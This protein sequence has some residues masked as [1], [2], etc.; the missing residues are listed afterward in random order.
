MKKKFGGSRNWTQDL[1][2]AAIHQTTTFP[3]VMVAFV[4]VENNQDYV[5]KTNGIVNFIGLLMI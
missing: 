4:P 1:L 5:D 2:I 3:K